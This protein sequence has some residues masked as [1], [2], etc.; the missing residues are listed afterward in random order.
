MNRRDFLKYAA[1]V[2]GTTMYPWG[3]PQ[4]AH[5]SSSFLNDM[6]DRTSRKYLGYGPS[7][8]Y[9]AGNL[10]QGKASRVAG[11]DEDRGILYSIYSFIKMIISR[12][13]K[14]IIFVGENF[15]FFASIGAA[16]LV[17]QRVA[18]KEEVFN[19]VRFTRN[20]SSVL[21][22]PDISYFSHSNFTDVV[23]DQPKR[24]ALH[25]GIV[26]SYGDKLLVW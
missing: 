24:V 3:P 25:D 12:I 21:F 15:E 1:S 8:N 11:P 18:K 14:V 22:T 17:G 4:R 19:G 2:G 6:I 10:V 13:A 16:V 7:Y 26:G 20:S 23:Y 9:P 5:Q